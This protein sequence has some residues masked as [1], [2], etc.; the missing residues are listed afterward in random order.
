M[1]VLALHGYMQDGPKMETALSKLLRGKL[2]PKQ[3]V[4]P[5][6]PHQVAAGQFGW[7][8]LPSRESIRLP[9]TY[10]NIE[11]SLLYLSDIIKR[12]GPFD[13]LIG[14][15]QGAVL[16]T[17]LASLFPS[18]FRYIILM[19]GS[20]IMDLRW[21]PSVP[22]TI[23]VLSLVG[24]RDDLC[25]SEDTAQ[26]ES[27]YTNVT[28]GTHKYGHVIPTDADTRRLVE[29]FLAPLSYVPMEI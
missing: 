5:T 14:F 18:S 28:R 25:L 19:S 8:P 21:H 11:A 17:I 7:W 20:Q 24:Q 9:H 29:I 16:A 15:S 6:G 13:C 23:P 27:N 22:I 10:D 4:A 3:I 12:E 2:K 26:L 1:K